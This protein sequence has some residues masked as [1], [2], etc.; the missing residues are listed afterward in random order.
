MYSLL[1]PA[2]KNK[3]IEKIKEMKKIITVILGIGLFS[4]AT[5]AE[6]EDIVKSS[7]KKV[8]VYTQGAQIERK[9]S[10]SVSKGI[11]T[12]VIEG[13]SPNIDP[14]SLQVQASGEIVILDSKYTI[15]Y[16]QPDPVLNP[17]NGI[18]PKILQE[19]SLLQDSIFNINFD[20]SEIQYQIDVLNSE[21]RIIENNGTIK[22]QG[23]VNDSIPLLE[24]A[25]AFYH[26]K[27]LEINGQLLKLNRSQQLKTRVHGRMNTR[28]G[29][30]QNYNTN[31]N[32]VQTPNKP[33]VHQVKITISA[34]EAANG[35]VKLSYLVNNAGWTPSYDLRSS[36]ADKQINLTYKAQVHQNTGI[37][38]EGVNLSLSTNNPYA[39]KTK[40]TLSPWYLDYY[41]YRNNTYKD[42]NQ[43]GNAPTTTL[44]SADMDLK[45]AEKRRDE[46]E[47]A[48]EDF[49]ALSATNF[50]KMI[51][52]L[53]SVEYEIDLP[54][55]I[56]SDNQENMVL[57]NTKDLNTEFM[58]YAIPKI[59][60]SVFMVARIT[61]LG[62]LNLIPG[63]ANLFHD[64][65]YLGNT[66]IDPNTM[67]DTLDLSLGKDPNLVMKRTLLKNESK[68]KVVGDKIVK[69]VSYKIELKNHK[70]SSIRLIVQDQVPVS[71]N[72]EIE[73][74]LDDLSKGK[75]N[76]ITG[77]V[78]W[79]FKM[80]P[81]DSEEIDI[82]FTVKYDKTQNVNLAF[83]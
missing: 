82:K 8:T 49:D 43:P 14:N 15:F 67:N 27:M 7:I 44:G 39:N 83:N 23:K 78:E 53:I 59:D 68:E 16:P 72:K 50:T 52:H 64:G 21:K 28:L 26:K 36:A 71:R 22:G 19:I 81:Q 25:I 47:L 33:P 76:E 62:D 17:K 9:A 3:N 80:K 56:K 46:L 79:N 37:D 57:V 24:A 61:N 32:F 6:K 45:N 42:Y 73:V 55:S 54:Y 38:W 63:K 11:T 34:K 18:P 60:L 4:F 5:F 40:P 31:N 74:S 66:Y 13:V 30:L 51:E 48:E 65:A 58:Y 12:L 41:T 29:Q 69:T 1:R 77:I 35:R 70:S 10:Y 20:I 75:L 2:I